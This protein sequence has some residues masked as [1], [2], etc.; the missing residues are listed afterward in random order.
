MGLCSWVLI[1]QTCS[2]GGGQQVEGSMGESGGM[3]QGLMNQSKGKALEERDL[4]VPSFG[5][6]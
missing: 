6:W 4:H 3:N 2:V 5:L 1:F